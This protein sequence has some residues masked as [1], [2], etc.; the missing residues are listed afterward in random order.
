MDLLPGI[1][2]HVESVEVI[3]HVAIQL[4]NATKEINCV[5]IDDGQ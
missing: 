4:P 1:G 2:V 5:P 3:I